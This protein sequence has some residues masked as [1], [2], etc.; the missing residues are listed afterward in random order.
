MRHEPHP[1]HVI[2][3]TGDVM[4]P[5]DLPPA[6]VKRWVPRR[7]AQIVVAV[8][9]GLLSLAEAQDRYA[10]SAEEFLAWERDYAEGGLG[11]LRVSHLH[12]PHGPSQGLPH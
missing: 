9:A 3:P 10:I 5:A 1:A 4:T 12:R 7:K 8:H 11:A 2:G 6:R